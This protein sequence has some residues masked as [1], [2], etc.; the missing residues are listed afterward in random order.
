MLRGTFIAIA[1]GRQG[2]FT[3]EGGE[4]AVAL[5]RW[6]WWLY[7]YTS[8]N[9]KTPHLVIPIATSSCS[10]V[11]CQFAAALTAAPAL[12]CLSRQTQIRS[13]FGRGNG[14]SRLQIGV[15]FPL[16]QRFYVAFFLG[17]ISG[18]GYH[19]LYLNHCLKKPRCPLKCSLSRLLKWLLPSALT[20]PMASEEC[21]SRFSWRLPTN[22]GT[23]TYFKVLGCPGSLGSR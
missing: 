23:C 9:F 6:E 13:W 16:Y 8:T 1:K 7:L 4:L 18:L 5:G 2:S 17:T 11:L 21:Q 10:T 15:M 19:V 22:Q 12:C 3:R 20:D 14:N